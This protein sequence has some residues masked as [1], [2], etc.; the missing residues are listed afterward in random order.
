MSLKLCHIMNNISHKKMLKIMKTTN[1]K[2]KSYLAQ[3]YKENLRK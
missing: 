1:I 2:V 3:L